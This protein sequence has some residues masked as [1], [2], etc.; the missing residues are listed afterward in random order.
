MTFTAASRTQ[1][2]TAATSA[3]Q[4]RPEVAFTSQ[5]P[6]EAAFTSQ[7]LSEASFGPEGQPEIS[8]G[9]KPPVQPLQQRA[10]EGRKTSSTAPI[11]P[12]L[13]GRDPLTTSN[14]GFRFAP[15]PANFGLALRANTIGR[16]NAISDNRL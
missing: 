9:R 8:R 11:L 2:L 3:P 16:G 5:D 7:D 13:P 6:S 10:P 4:A 15:P 1:R 12:P 14:R